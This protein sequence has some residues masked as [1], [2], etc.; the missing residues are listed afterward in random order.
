MSRRPVSVTNNSGDPTLSLFYIERR[1]NPLGVRIPRY[2]PD[3]GGSL[4]S[5]PRER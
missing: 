5:S 3:P 4:P 2:R 1:V